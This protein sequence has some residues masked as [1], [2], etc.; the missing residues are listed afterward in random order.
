MPCWSSI[1]NRAEVDIHCNNA[2]GKSCRRSEGRVKQV[3]TQKPVL[4]VDDEEHILTTSRLFLQN[5]G[6]GDI[7]TVSHSR[8]VLPLLESQPVAVIVLDLHMPHMSG[9]ELL[10]KIVRDFPHIPVIVVTANDAI[11][12]VVE[13]MKTGAFDYLVKPVDPSRLVVSVRKALDMSRTLQRIV[14]PQTGPS[15]RRTQS[16]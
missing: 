10:P 8:D 14:L 12:T 3:T 1:R 6:I 7:L 9:L 4:L 5:S 16:S 2:G 15:D 11:E 13:C